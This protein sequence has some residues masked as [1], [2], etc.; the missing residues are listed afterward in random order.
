MSLTSQNSNSDSH[1]RC[2]YAGQRPLTATFSNGS[3]ASVGKTSATSNTSGIRYPDF[4][5]IS[6]GADIV[7]LQ[8]LRCR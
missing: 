4:S 6:L 2:L 1:K 8:S 3:T 5:D 7:R